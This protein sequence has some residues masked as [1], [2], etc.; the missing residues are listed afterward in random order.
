[1]QP[2]W[3]IYD[4]LWVPMAAALADGRR[5]L[6]GWLED[7]G[8]WAGCL[9]LRELLQEPDGMLAMRWP[10]EVVP[11]TVPAPDPAW[12]AGAWPRRLTADSSAV[13]TFADGLP[14]EY[15]LDIAIEPARGAG[16]YALV[17]GGSGDL[18]DGCELRL[19]PRRRRAQWH[20]PRHGRPAPEVPD[21]AEI[22]A[23]PEGQKP[24]HLQ[25]SPNLHF[26]GGDFAIANVEGLDRPVNVR[27][28]VLRDRKS[29][30]TIVDAEIGGRRTLITRRRGL[31]G[32]RLH[33]V[34]TAGTVTF[35]C[36]T[37]RIPRRGP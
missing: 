30:S 25:H 3:D 16:A 8:G 20:T 17:V 11:P 29:G 9:V 19:D 5:I 15:L 31:T 14:E 4:G 13:W 27:L 26:H 6:S 12:Q 35:N 21:P 34:A 33:L 22:F 1:M 2:R 7:C 10:P 18:V 36:P 32:R 23:T 37:L 24:L 28:L